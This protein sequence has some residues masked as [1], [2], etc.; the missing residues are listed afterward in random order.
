ME[1]KE[2]RFGNYVIGSKNAFSNIYKKELICNIQRIDCN[3]D[4]GIKLYH[5]EKPIYILDSINNIKPIPLT[6]EWLLKFGFKKYKSSIKYKNSKQMFFSFGRGNRFKIRCTTDMNG[7]NCID[8][9]HTF[10]NCG[11]LDF[12]HELQNLY[13]AL[14]KKELTI[15]NK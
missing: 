12:V 7:K 8:F 13:Y 6:E 14:T 1:A 11:N 4:L 5:S 10:A 9:N 3:S 15:K 2:L